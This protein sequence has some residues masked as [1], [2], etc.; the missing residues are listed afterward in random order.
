[1]RNTTVTREQQKIEA[2]IDRIERLNLELAELAFDPDLNLNTKIGAMTLDRTS[3]IDSD[4]AKYLC[5]R[6]SGFVEVSLREICKDYIRTHIAAGSPMEH[7]INHQWSATKRGKSANRE[8][9]LSLLLEFDKNWADD[10][11]RNK[12]PKNSNGHLALNTVMEQ[13]NKIAHGEDSNITLADLKAYFSK[14]VQVIEEFEK[15]FKP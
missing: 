8:M 12:F 13:R 1:M 9:I 4:Q 6:I 10:F 7:Y 5:I 3:E 11:K 14:I 15:Q 2:L